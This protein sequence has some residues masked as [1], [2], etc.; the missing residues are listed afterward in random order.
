MLTPEVL[1]RWGDV[2]RR[3]PLRVG[4]MLRAGCVGRVCWKPEGRM[5]LPLP[6]EGEEVEK[7]EAE[8]EEDEGRT[9]GADAAEKDADGR[10]SG[11]ETARGERRGD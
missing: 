3:S 9:F 2:D 5:T 7:E 10:C 6:E 8:K 1:D 11:V 4:D